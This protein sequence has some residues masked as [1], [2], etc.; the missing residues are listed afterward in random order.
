MIYLRDLRSGELIVL[1]TSTDGKCV[2]LKIL[3]R[4]SKRQATPPR[5]GALFAEVRDPCRMGET[6]FS[7]WLV[8]LVLVAKSRGA[9]EARC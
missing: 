4:E 5:Y 9:I 7:D 2:L 1:G 3:L 6:C 8:F